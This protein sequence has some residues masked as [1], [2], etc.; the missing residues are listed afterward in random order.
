MSHIL[1]KN[2]GKA[3]QKDHFVIRHLNLEIKDDEFL[4]LVGPSGCG[5][6]T[7]LRM[8]AGLEEITEGE[9]YIDGILQNDKDPSTR[10]LSF[11]F[12]D[13]ALLPSLTVFENIQFGLIDSHL[14][15]LE[16]YK[17][18]EDIAIKMSLLDR[19]GSYPHQLSGGQKQRVALARALIDG[20]KLVMFDEPLSNLDAVLRM[21]M[22]TEITRLKENFTLTGVYV[23]HDQV[24]AMSM[25]DRIALMIDGEIQQIGTPE[26]MYH[27][28]QKLSVATFIGSPEINIFQLIYQDNQ[29]WINQQH[30][31]VSSQ[32]ESIA[33]EYENRLLTFTIRPQ[34]I[35]V[36]QDYK[37]DT[38]QSTITI[39]ENLGS[40]KLLHINL[41]DQS[42]QVV[43]DSN[44]VIDQDVYIDLTGV[45]YLFDEQGNRLT[46]KKA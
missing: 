29:T 45:G 8:I 33:K 7:L 22:R 4:V 41:F 40:E 24:E 28:P 42:I 43:V 12:Q 10:K 2:V 30:V 31:K 23:T 32:I 14:S 39:I 26:D 5:K 20:K 18:V 46:V 38:Y 11:V 9:I 35:R 13:Y 17:M 16:K 21:S 44:T 25:A 36:Y 37:P 34:D 6:T 19:L 1:L 27:N 15:K 3:Y